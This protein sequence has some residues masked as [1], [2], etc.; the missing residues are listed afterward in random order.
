MANCEYRVSQNTAGENFVG[1]VKHSVTRKPKDVRPQ[2]AIVA[3][4]EP[5]ELCQVK[6]DQLNHYPICE[7]PDASTASCPIAQFRKGNMNLQETNR[8]LTEIFNAGK[9]SQG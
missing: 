7:L 8:R 9:S 3:A 4:G 2:G 1:N 5:V 6:L